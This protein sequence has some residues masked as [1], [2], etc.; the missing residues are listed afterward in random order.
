MKKH[1]REILTP[2]D[3]LGSDFVDLC[4]LK[5]YKIF[6]ILIITSMHFKFMCDKMR[7]SMSFT[8]L[9]VLTT[10]SNKAS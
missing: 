8:L 10:L 5:L 7:R 3:R 1:E 4:T 9:A 6:K 2:R